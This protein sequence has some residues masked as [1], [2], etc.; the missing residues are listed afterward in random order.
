MVLGSRPWEG[1]EV[2]R[3]FSVLIRAYSQKNKKSGRIAAFLGLDF[4]S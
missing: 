2:G 1:F 4:V 3:H